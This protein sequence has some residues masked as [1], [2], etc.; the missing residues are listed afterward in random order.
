[1][2]RNILGNRIVETYL[3]MRQRLQG[4][5][6]GDLVNIEGFAGTHVEVLV[7]VRGYLGN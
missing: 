3:W 2:H 6:E 1:M 7:E 5:Y 4:I